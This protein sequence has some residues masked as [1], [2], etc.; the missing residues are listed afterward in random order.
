M[1]CRVQ[2]E[3]PSFEDFFPSLQN[4][5]LCGRILR[6]IGLGGKSRPVHREVRQEIVYRY[7][8]IALR[9]C[10]LSSDVDGVNPD[11]LLAALS[12]TAIFTD[13]HFPLTLSGTTTTDSFFA[14]WPCC[15]PASPPA[16]C[17]SFFEHPATATMTVRATTTSLNNTFTCP[18]RLQNLT[19]MTR[20]V[21][22]LAEREGFEPS[23]QVLPVYS[24]SRRAPSTYSAISPI[25]VY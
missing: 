5:D 15:A 17:S 3:Q 22:Y 8:E 4:P 24:L 13:F 7:R 21:R 2:R 14:A 18:P 9:N 23:I 10:Q 19:A 11:S 20:A 6:L 16:F 25:V 12:V 1:G